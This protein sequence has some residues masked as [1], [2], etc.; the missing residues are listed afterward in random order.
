MPERAILRELFNG[1]YASTREAAEQYRTMADT[2]GDP[3]RKD[4]LARLAR[5]GRRHIDLTERLLE[6][7]SE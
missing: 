5:D 1:L 3:A 7:L 4:Q 6:I 2:A